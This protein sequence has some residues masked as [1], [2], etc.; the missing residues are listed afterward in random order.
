MVEIKLGP[1]LESLKKMDEE[2]VSEPFDMVFIDADKINHAE[3]FKY[4]LKF[5]K[6]GT[7]IVLDN[8]VRDGRVGDANSSNP[9]IQGVRRMFEVLKN[10]KRVEC[11]ALQ[12]VGSKGWDGLA[13]ALVIE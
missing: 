12:T 2:G 5:G 1:A 7:V 6:K 13:I 4:A 9:M 8:V 3:Y 10:E 11:T